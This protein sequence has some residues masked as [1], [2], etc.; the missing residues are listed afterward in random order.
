MGTLDNEAIIRSLDSENMLQSIQDLPDQVEAAWHQSQAITLPT[1]YIQAQAIVMLGLGASRVAAEVVRTLAERQSRRP[2]LVVSDGKLP[3]FVDSS[4][5]VIGVSYTG[6]TPEVVSAFAEAG[7]RGAKLLGVSAGGDLASLCRKYRAPAFPIQYGAYPRAA[8][9]YLLIPIIATLNR[10]G[11]LELEHAD[12]R[13]EQLVHRLRDTSSRLRPE[14]SSIQNPAKQLAEY[15]VGYLPVLVGSPATLPALQRWQQQLQQNAKVFSVIDEAPALLH[16]GVEGWSYPGKLDQTVRYVT[17]AT[18][19]DTD[20]DA[21]NLNIFRQL[22][23]KHRFEVKDVLVERSDLLI[24]L[25]DLILW[26]DY[27]SYYLALLNGVDPSAT[28]TIQEALGQKT[29]A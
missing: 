14:S 20:D 10:L 25:C 7:R 21:L 29:S 11:F 28:P 17:L 18:S 15:L 6:K 13:I 22:A 2:V 9:G 23:K 8:L 19:D 26:A 1:H 16:G 27:V 4:T 3:S 12:D 5:L 24:E